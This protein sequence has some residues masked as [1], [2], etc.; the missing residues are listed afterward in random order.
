MKLYSLAIQL[1]STAAFTA[2]VASPSSV[3][4]V[5]A[6][7]K[8]YDKIHRDIDGAAAAAAT[9]RASRDLES[10]HTTSTSK[11]S[12]S[13]SYCPPEPTP[14]VQCGSTY[15][16]STVIL[17]QNLLCNENITEADG[18]F[19]AVLTLSGEKA[20]LNCQGYT[21]SQTTV[22]ID[23]IDTGSAASLD[24]PIIPINS[25]ERLR[26]KQEC[27]LFFLWGVILKDGARMVNCNIQKFWGGAEIV[28]GGGIV[29]SEFSLNTRGVNLSNGAANAVSK[30]VNR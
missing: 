16:D 19:N 7:A 20:L 10:I 23:G 5:E 26:W 8:K 29:D 28:N 15:V 27:G 12:K 18:S 13:S 22:N 24:C 11:S 14:D 4:V 1:L 21:I 3:S 9:S 17:G 30:V 2:T 25:T 6:A